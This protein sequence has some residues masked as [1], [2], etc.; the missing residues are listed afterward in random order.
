MVID[1]TGMILKERYC[2]LEQIGRGSEGKLYLARDMELGGYWAVKE[3]SA[4]R[5]R[6]AKLLRLLEHPSIPRMVD[7]A[8]REDACYL[9]MEYIRGHSLQE[10]LEEGK[11][12]SAEEI[13]ELGMEAAEVLRY[14]HTRKPPVY[15]GDLKPANLMLG[16][17]GKLYLVDFGS[18][19]WGYSREQRV[20]LGTK[21]FAAP[22]QFEGRMGEQSDVYALGRT[23]RRLAGKGWHR[24]ILRAPGL[25]WFV[26]KCCRRSE[27][28]RYRDMKEAGRALLKIRQRLGRG[29]RNR[30][31][32]LAAAA[33]LCVAGYR[34]LDRGQGFFRALEEITAMYREPEFLSGEKD[35]IREICGEAEVRLQRLQK[36][37]TD[38]MEQRKL[39]LLLAVN[40]EL[41]E[42]WERAALYYEQLLLYDPGYREGYGEYGMFLWRAG[43]REACLKLWQDYEKLEEEGA[44][45]SGS[46][47]TL[48]MWKERMDEEIRKEERE[49][50]SAPAGG[51]VSDGAGGGA[52]G[53]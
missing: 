24:V 35:R 53:W 3:I 52:A 33:I 8:E 2:I 34:Y 39:L 46:G 18:A 32:S 6:E 29:R 14:L 48:S 22:E 1:L 40:G 30:L 10:L 21:G 5:K 12:F 23:V 19:V 9:V 16:D 51:G 38:K 25:I 37:Y 17:S 42:E 47:R 45:E 28:R 44:L 4:D 36:E 41:Q 13:L 50:G 26:N 27:K 7:L 20:C 43:Q 49:C 15:Y 11:C 31:I